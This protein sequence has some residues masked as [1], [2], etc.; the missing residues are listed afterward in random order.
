MGSLVA[1]DSPSTWGNN[2]SSLI[3]IENVNGIT[4]DGSGIEC[5][6]VEW[7]DP[8]VR[9]GSGGDVI[10]GWWSSVHLCEWCSMLMWVALLCCRGEYRMFSLLSIWTVFLTRDP[11]MTKGTDFKFDRSKQAD[12]RS[13][14]CFGR[15]MESRE[16]QS[17]MQRDDGMLMF[18]H[19]LLLVFA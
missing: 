16:R 12:V 18:F 5:Q 3:T 4:I 14:I 2:P 10:G 8:F 19:A 17:M 13:E 1:P 11:R 7:P 6:G 9:C 15:Q